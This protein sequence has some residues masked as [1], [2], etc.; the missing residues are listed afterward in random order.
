MKKFLTR[1]VRLR[2]FTALLAAFMVA[3]CSP[4]AANDD[5]EQSNISPH[6]GKSGEDVAGGNPILTIQ[7]N[8]ALYVVRELSD[9][10]RG[11][12]RQEWIDIEDRRDNTLATYNVSNA[13]ELNVALKAVGAG[14]KILLGAGDYGAVSLKNLTFDANI[15]IASKDPSAQAVI[16]KL[17]VAGSKGITFT[18]LEFSTNGSVKLGGLFSV[19]GSSKITFDNVYVHGSLNGNPQDDVDGI[20]LVDSKDVTITNSEFEQLRIAISHRDGDGMNISGNHIHDIRMDGIRGSGSSD[21]LISKNYITDF[22]RVD[23]D[24]ADA[25]QFFTGNTTEA[26]KNITITDNIIDRG[27]GLKMQGIFI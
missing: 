8:H 12:L 24:H 17:D 15:T 27:D 1:W 13:A 16:T 19:V 9:R 10:A 22:Y 6:I 11:N 26:A 25:I 4:S 2:V 21:I 7:F 18:D 3:S 20:R 23:G 5:R 14:D